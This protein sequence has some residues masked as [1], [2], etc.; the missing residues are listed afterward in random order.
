MWL[1]PDSDKVDDIAKYVEVLLDLHHF[2]KSTNCPHEE[3]V[4]IVLKH[5]EKVEGTVKALSLI[6]DAKHAY[7]VRGD[8][9]NEFPSWEAFLQA[10]AAILDD[11]NRNIGGTF[12][13]FEKSKTG[14]T[15]PKAYLGKSECS[16]KPG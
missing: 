9:G 1:K 16:R 15:E 14:E 2:G 8:F 13:V 4:V 7:T 3:N 10:V 12:P 6:Q 5:L 11:G